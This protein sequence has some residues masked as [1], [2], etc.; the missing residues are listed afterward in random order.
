MI[1]GVQWRGVSKVKILV[2]FIAL[3]W[4]LPGDQGK[5]LD[6]NSYSSRVIAVLITS[7]AKLMERQEQATSAH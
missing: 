6:T 2:C 7:D 4:N 5:S 3:F 1:G